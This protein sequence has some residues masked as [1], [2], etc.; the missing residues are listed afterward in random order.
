MALSRDAAP[1]RPDAAQLSEPIPI[2]HADLSAEALRGVIESFVLR[3]GT[4][5]GAREYSLEQKVAH[6]RAQ[7]ERGQARILFDP[8]SNTVT[9][10]QVGA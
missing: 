3:E 7:L 2:P 1:P 8:E 4:D 10:V 9:L 6:V 5:Y